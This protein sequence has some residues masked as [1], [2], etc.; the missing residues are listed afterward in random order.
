[1]EAQSIYAV[2]ITLITVGSAGVGDFMNVEPKQ[3]RSMMTLLEKIV[4]NE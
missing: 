1:M 4:Q 3:N 2:L